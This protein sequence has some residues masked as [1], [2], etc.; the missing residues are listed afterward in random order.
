MMKKYFCAVALLLALPFAPGCKKSDDDT[1]TKPSLSGLYI[2]EA[3]P[4]VAVG[5]TLT[6][7]ADIS[8]LTVSDGTA[9]TIGIYWQVNSSPK[10]T[11]TKDI[12]KSNPDF[13]YKVD[14]LGNYNVF[15]YAFAGSDYYA[16]STTATFKAIDPTNVLS[17]I[18]TA[19]EISVKGKTWKSRNATHATAGISFRNAPILDAPLGRLFSWE[20]AQTVCPAGWHLPTVAEFEA[21]FAG[22]DGKISAGDLMADALFLE[23][24]MWAYWPSVTITNQ[25]GFNAIPL[26]YIDTLDNF[27]TFDKYGE[28]ACWW[29]ADQAAGL[30]TYLY[31]YQ[32]YPTVQKGQGDKKSLAMGVR[33][34]KD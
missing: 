32:E 3:P 6:F 21:S 9:P 8:S 34:V 29:T 13:K 12:S 11:L 19:E 26:G 25:Y 5:T 10:D 27:N 24:K 15:C 2:N 28:Y 7:Q 23:E 16:T 18:G 14:T 30:G 22:A 17:G 33:C 4:F 1:T 20:E 31:I